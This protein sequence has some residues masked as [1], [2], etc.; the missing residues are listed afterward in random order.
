[1]E[2]THG[3]NVQG[4]TVKIALIGDSTVTDDSGWGKA[5]ASRFNNN[6]K[7]LN[8]AFNGRSS[9]SWYD[10]NHLPKVL[11]AKPDYMLIQFG[12]ND[13]PGKG[14]ERETD[15]ATT[16]HDYLKMYIKEFRAIGAKPIIVS[17]VTRRNFDAD[18]KIESSLTP[19]AKAAQM[20]AKE[21]NAPFIDLHTSSTVGRKFVY[22]FGTCR[23]TV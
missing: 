14:P 6:V 10:E 7:V 2:F 16:Y 12:H 17:S 13:Q 23:P 3:V 22:P 8:F 1:M 21:L 19:W 9:K 4:D 20:V 15:P 18:G 11:S 5:F